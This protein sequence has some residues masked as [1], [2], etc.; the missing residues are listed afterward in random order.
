MTDKEKI[1]ALEIIKGYDSINKK[2]DQIISSLDRL[3]RKKTETLHDLQIL[4][5]RELKFLSDYREKYSRE[6]S[7]SLPDI[8]NLLSK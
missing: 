2:L 4:R 1:E 6:E 3:E 8:I 7:L 5:D